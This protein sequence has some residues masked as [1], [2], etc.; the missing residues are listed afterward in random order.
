MRKNQYLLLIILIIFPSIESY[1]F[2][3]AVIHHLGQER[4]GDGNG[5]EQTDR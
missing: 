2:N 1:T 3:Q 4:P 5:A